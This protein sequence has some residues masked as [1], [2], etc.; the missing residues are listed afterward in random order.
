VALA[1]RIMYRLGFTP[2]DTGTV[3]PP[4]AEF[5]QSEPTARALDIGCGTG[6][7]S[8]YLAKHGWDVTGIDE[9]E[10][11]LRL[12]RE[13]ARAAGVEVDWRQADAA[14]LEAADLEPGFALVLDRGCFHGLSPAQ[15][16]GFVHGVTALSTPDATLLLM[17][18]VRNRVPGGPAGADRADVERDF[19]PEWRIASEQ[20]DPEP[21][22]TGPMGKVPIT[23]YELVR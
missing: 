7:Q 8:V 3:P 19:S 13:R 2:W 4:L 10:R 22:P 15:R 16:R 11:P 1:Y 23:W 6:T 12:A 18:F 21:P 14:K 20:P 5:V 9:I 17:T